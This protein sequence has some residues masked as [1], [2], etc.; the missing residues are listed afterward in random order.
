M[1]EVR[2]N[3]KDSHST[4]ASHGRLTME[5]MIENAI[6]VCN[7]MLDPKSPGV[8][9]RLLEVCSGVA[10]ISTAEAGFFISASGGT[11]IVIRRDESTGKWSP[12]SAIGTGGVGFGLAFGAEVKDIVMVMI[13]EAAVRAL[14]GEVQVKLG[15]QMAIAAGPIGREAEGA[16]TLSNKGAG[17]T[18]TYSI[19]K[20]LFAGINMEGAIVGA[21]KAENKKFYNSDA[22]PH[23]ILFTEGAVLIPDG[24]H[25]PT[26]HQ[27]LTLMEQGKTV[28]PSHDI[29]IPSS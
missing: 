2:D 7:Y 17:M 12:P 24:S 15:G 16:F 4:A 1:A 19:V 25:I 18:F 22:S 6:R 29:E 11:G 28:D 13:D 14:S 23:D 21:R 9:R 5:G 10:F 8:P 26:L 3:S 20:G 27:K